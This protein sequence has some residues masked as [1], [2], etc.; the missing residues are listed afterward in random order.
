MSNDDRD[1]LADAFRR[2]GYLQADIDSLG[3][4][5]PYVHPEIA[6]AVKAAPPRTLSRGGG[7]STA[8]R[9]R[10]SSCTSSTPSAA[11][12]S[13]GWMEGDRAAPD[14]GKIVEQLARSELFERFVHARY[15]GSKRYSIEGVAGVIPL[16]ESILD[17]FARNGGEL[18]MIAMSHRGRLNVLRTSRTSRHRTSSPEW[19]TSTHEA[20]WGAAT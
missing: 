3:R 9:R 16:L 1:N 11:A 2:W 18:A 12:G 4:L 5:E 20:S 10:S 19:K 13:P 8:G 6:L 17:G 14:R 7:G 15:V